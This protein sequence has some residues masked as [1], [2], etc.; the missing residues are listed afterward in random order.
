MLLSARTDAITFCLW[1]VVVVKNKVETP[2]Q[3]G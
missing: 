3:V 1:V 2:V